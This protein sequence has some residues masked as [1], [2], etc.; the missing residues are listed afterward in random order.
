M[1][2][3]YRLLL[4]L[5]HTVGDL[6]LPIMLRQCERVDSTMDS[7]TPAKAE[8]MIPALERVLEA[9]LARPSELKPIIHEMRLEIGAERFLAGEVAPGGVEGASVLSAG[10]A[11]EEPAG[12]RSERES[13]RASRH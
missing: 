6:A 2:L 11:G 12:R 10:R 4:I 1:K 8:R 9:Y 3:A 5:G 7:L 13:E